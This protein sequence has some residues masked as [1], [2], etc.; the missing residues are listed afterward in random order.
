MILPLRQYTGHRARI[1]EYVE[2]RLRGRWQKLVEYRLKGRQQEHVEYRVRGRI[3]EQ[4]Y[5]VR[6]RS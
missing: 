5:R 2:Y 3:Q 6:R 4:G 1:Q